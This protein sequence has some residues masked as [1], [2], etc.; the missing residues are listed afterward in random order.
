MSWWDFNAKE[1]K[2]EYFINLKSAVQLE[3]EKGPCYPPYDQIFE[4]F[5]IYPEE[6]KC[7]ILGQDPYHEPGQAM[8]L[9]FS[10]PHGQPIPPS[11]HNI[12]KEILAD[13]GRPTINTDGDLS[14]WKKQGVFLLN[15]VLTVRAHEAGSHVGLGWEIYT[16]EV[17]KL[18]NRMN[19]PMVFMLWGKHAQSKV[20]LLTNKYHLVLQAAHPSPFSANKGFMGCKHFSKC[21]EYLRG[22]GLK[23]II[24]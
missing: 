23:E 4:A 12:Y 24:W 8:G 13:T 22:Y 1:V 10:V 21:N 6:I 2:K 3:Y 9:A 11:L 17:I 18:L 7:V 5:S 20:P 16:D 15:S 19:Q 14:T